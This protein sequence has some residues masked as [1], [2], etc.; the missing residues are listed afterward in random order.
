[1]SAAHVPSAHVSSVF[2]GERMSAA[3][4]AGSAAIL[5]A[6]FGILPNGHKERT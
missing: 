5:A 3:Y 2:G 1:M 6:T 4:L